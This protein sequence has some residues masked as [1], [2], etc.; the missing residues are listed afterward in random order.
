MYYKLIIIQSEADLP[1]E[2]GRYFVI[3][4]DGH[5]GE[6]LFSKPERLSNAYWLNNVH[7]YYAPVEVDDWVSV[8]T[9]V[10]PED[11]QKVLFITTEG[12]QD[13]AEFNLKVLDEYNCFV[14]NAMVYSNV[15]HWRTLPAP[16]SSPTK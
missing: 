1:K 16:P 13:V 14:A 11:K 3:Y 5:T 7:S 12:R 6:I 4:K 9:R 15:T 10:F 2:S 8:A